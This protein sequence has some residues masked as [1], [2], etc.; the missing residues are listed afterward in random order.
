MLDRTIFD[1]MPIPIFLVGADLEVLDL[2]AA[3]VQFCGQ[4][5]DAVYRRRG[6]DV[7]HCLHS[8]D[9]PQGCG[10]GPACVD[11][12][13]RNSVSQSLTGQIV[14]RRRINLQITQDGLTRD[15]QTLITTCPVSDGS[16]KQALLMIEDI[17]ELSGLKSLVPI[18]ANCKKVRN[19]EQFWQSLEHYLRLNAG[20]DFSH[21]ICPSCADQLY[22][23]LRQKTTKPAHETS[24][25]EER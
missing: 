16:E 23:D 10:R 25:S 8:T 20:V 21:G 5:K 6:G 14:S 17:T 13:I 9:V 24:L 19:D 7:L 12:L 15:L 1:A 22:P 4:T 18:C 2:N 3:A 11:C